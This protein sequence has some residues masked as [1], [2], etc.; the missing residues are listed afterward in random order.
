MRDPKTERLLHYA[1]MKFARDLDTRF[2]MLL[3]TGRLAKWYSQIGSEATTV[4]AGLAPASPA[5]CCAR[6][7]ATWGPSSRSTSIRRA[8]FPASA[9]AS[10]TAS[11][12]EPGRPSVPP[13]LPAA[14]PRRRLLERRRALV[15]LRLP[16]TRAGHPPHRHDQPPRAMIPVA[17][18][19]AYALK[20]DDGHPEPRRHSTSSATAAPPPATSTRASTW[21]RC[22]S[23]R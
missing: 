23:C 19:A 18:G 5:T 12:P 22:G 16:G 8:P 20:H 7:T 2:T 15:P 1:Y 4:A 9:S 17:A 14:R 21:P 13:V 6:C 11:R 3:R 10:A